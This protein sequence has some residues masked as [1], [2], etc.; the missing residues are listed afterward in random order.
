MPSNP[1]ANSVPSPATYN[2]VPNRQTADFAVHWMKTTLVHLREQAILRGSRPDDNVI[3]MTPDDVAAMFDEPMTSPVWQADPFDDKLLI[4]DAGYTSSSH[5]GIGEGP[6]SRLLSPMD[7]DDDNNKN[8]DHLFDGDVKMLDDSAIDMTEVNN[9]DD[10]F[11]GDVDMEELTR[12]YHDI[13]IDTALP[14]AYPDNWT[15][16][17]TAPFPNN[18]TDAVMA[19]GDD[20]NNKHD[21]K[22]DDENDEYWSQV[23]QWF[24]EEQE[25]DDAAG[26]ERGA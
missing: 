26:R 20:N 18:T 10:L 23:E 16:T 4:E 3:T 13:D 12:D 11:E 7:E 5:V 17:L 22:D 1:G 15:S 24:L 8:I 25:Q 2:K 21:D 14:D 19:D 9:L 6:E